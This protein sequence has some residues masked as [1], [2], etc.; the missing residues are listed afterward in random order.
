MV[1][2]ATSDPVQGGIEEATRW[3]RGLKGRRLRPETPRMAVRLLVHAPDCTVHRFYA[4][5][6]AKF[7]FFQWFSRP[8]AYASSMFQQL[9]LV[10]ICTL[11]P[12]IKRLSRHHAW[13][14][15]QKWPW[16]VNKV[17]VLHKAPPSVHVNHASSI[18]FFPHLSTLLSTWSLL[19][20]GCKRF[21][22]LQF[23]FR[24]GLLGLYACTSHHCWTRDIYDL[25]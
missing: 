9:I 24:R 4:F 3:Q 10:G 14:I 23:S 20:I 18:C 8:V 21:V 17:Q 6:H 22:H 25:R 7:F 1:I 5:L 19:F 12:I 2:L 13:M 11:S 16:C 15:L